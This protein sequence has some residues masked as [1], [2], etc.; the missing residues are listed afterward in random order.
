MFCIYNTHLQDMGSLLRAYLTILTNLIALLPIYKCGISH[1]YLGVILCS[2]T[3]LMAT[4]SSYV[5]FLLKTSKQNDPFTSY[6]NGEKLFFE[7]TVIK[8]I[9]IAYSTLK[10]I[11]NTGFFIEPFVMLFIGV[12]SE[13]FSQNI[14]KSAVLQSLM[15]VLFYG[16]VTF[17][18]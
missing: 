16:A 4:G 6:G 8:C 2:I 14:Q 15:N 11:T 9:L 12:T 17:S 1:D 13:L 10:S 18:I 3:L 7:T 5:K